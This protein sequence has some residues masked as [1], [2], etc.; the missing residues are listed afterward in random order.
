M[1]KVLGISI[2]AISSILIL[3]NCSNSTSTPS[4][5]GSL[6]TAGQMAAGLG[7][8]I[9][10]MKG[11]GGKLGTGSFFIPMG[12]ETDSLQATDVSTLSAATKCSVNAEPGDDT[13]LDGVVSGAERYS[14][15]HN[16]FALQKFYCS[17]ASDSNGPESVS[18]ALGTIQVVVC[19]IEKQLGSLSFNGVAVPISGLV[20]DTTCAS[21]SKLNSMGAGGASSIT[22]AFA[23]TVTSALNPTFSEI[24]GN[25]WYSH[26][27]RLASNDGTSIKYIIL[28]KFDPTVAGNPVDSGNFEFATLGT[29][30]IMQGTAIETTAGKISG[31]A[32][33]TKHLWYE[34]RVNRIKGSVS[35]P[36]CPA[37]SSSCGF[38]RHTR[39]STDISFSGGDISDVSNFSGIITD[40]NDSVGAGGSGNQR[41][42]VSASGS[43][44]TGL[45]GKIWNSPG[46]S[47]A[48]LSG[49]TLTT[50]F[51]AGTTTCIIGAASSISTTCG[52]SAAV[53]APATVIDTYFRPANSTAWFVNSTT[54]NGIGFSGPVTFADGQ[55][56]LP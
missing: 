7:G 21:Q 51:T 17:L 45:T 52:A 54:K 19:A 43:L 29:G 5:G 1:N 2:L 12:S 28:A 33:V 35:D 36:I 34:M 48:T 8:S 42:V 27:I 15:A 14:Q 30:S 38:T 40:G 18:G 49:N 46:N 22:I 56:I 39:I 25:T 10:T 9:T 44:S 53:L 23:G 47:P 26:G 50:G 6:T 55:F 37:D 31:G 20:L 3:S 41:H 13:N 24:P 4:L 11:M 32:A 16:N